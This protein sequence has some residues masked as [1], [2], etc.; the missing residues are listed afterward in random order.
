MVKYVFKKIKR[1]IRFRKY[2]VRILFSMI[3]KDLKISIFLLEIFGGY[4][5]DGKN[6]SLK[7]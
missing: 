2:V 7:L 3:I 6:K 1:Y 5:A 4:E